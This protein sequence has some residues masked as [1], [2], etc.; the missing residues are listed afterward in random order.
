MGKLYLDVPLNYELIEAILINRIADYFNLLIMSKEL[1]FYDTCSIQCHSNSANRKKIIDFIKANDGIIIITQTVLSEL[2]GSGGYIQSNVINYINEINHSGVKIILIKE[3]ESLEIIRRL[4][5]LNYQECNQLLGFAATNA[6]QNKDCIENIIKAFDLGKKVFF[7]KTEAK[8]LYKEFFEF[9][10]SKKTSGDSL[11]EELMFIIFIIFLSNPII[12]KIIFFS[13]DKH[14]LASLTGMNA[15]TQRHYEGRKVYH[16][17]TTTLIYKLY[18]KGFITLKE[19]FKELLDASYSVDNINVFYT[20]KY[21]IQPE[22]SSFD[23]SALID[24]VFNE[25]E[26]NI[27]F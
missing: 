17:T 13:N 6:K 12:P 15:Y 23:K 4:S 20:D 5:T 22:L 19:E 7:H 2:G 24:R 9:A 27:L 8:S 10:R 14:S 1:Y 18:K 3:E 26:F 11:A 21:S 25:D 16:L